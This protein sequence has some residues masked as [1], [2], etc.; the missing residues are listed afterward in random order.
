MLLAA[1]AFAQADITNGLIRYTHTS[2]SAATDDAFQFA[3]EDANGGSTSA[4]YAIRIDPT[5]P[6]AFRN[7]LSP[8][9]G[10]LTLGAVTATLL[11]A[12]YVLF[13]RR[14]A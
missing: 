10:G 3:V 6:A 4:V 9:A 14:D 7:D 13:E 11:V 2:N 12:A 8:L 5:V 1:D